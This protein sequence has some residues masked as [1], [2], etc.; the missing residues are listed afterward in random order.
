MMLTQQAGMEGRAAGTGLA[1]DLRA[2]TESCGPVTH[3]RTDMVD[4]VMGL[5]AKASFVTKVRPDWVRLH[6]FVN[7]CSVRYR[8]NPYHNWHHALDV[9]RTV[10]W[11]LTR[12]VLAEK[13]DPADKFWVMIAAVVHDLDHPGRNNTWEV[14]TASPLAQKYQNISVLERHSLDLALMLLDD[15][16]LRF[17]DAMTPDARARGKALLPELLIATDFGLHEELIRSFR[18]AVSS[19]P[20]RSNFGDPEFHLLALKAVLKA[21]D[22]G[23]VAKPF[24]RAVWWARRVM[25]EFWAQGRA[26]RARGL[27]IAPINDESRMTLRQAQM[28]FIQFV[29]QDLF[30]LLARVEPASVCL[31][32]TLRENLNR[33]GQLADECAAATIARVSAEFADN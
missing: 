28:G 24:D 15:P 8:A 1:P 20:E 9:T 7:E 29:A 18:S 4:Q 17:T 14:R 27:P 21:A 12:P 11:L 30:D 19:Y 6:R 25:L 13:L 5:F 16:F 31:A 23:N 26:E 33:Y 2:K 22:I 10:A 3:S 32:H